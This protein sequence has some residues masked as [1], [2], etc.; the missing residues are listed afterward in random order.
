MALPTSDID[1]LIQL[2]GRESTISHLGH[3]LD[4]RMETSMISGDENAANMSIAN[5]PSRHYMQVQQVHSQVKSSIGNSPHELIENNTM[6]NI[7]VIGDEIRR[8]EGGNHSREM[9]GRLAEKGV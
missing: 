6:N 8:K 9:T 3:S 1:I 7:V 2:G 4:R 5:T